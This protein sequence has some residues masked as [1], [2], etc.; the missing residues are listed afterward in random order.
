MSESSPADHRPPKS[1]ARLIGPIVLAI[2]FI[3]A[4]AAYPLAV[5]YLNPPGSF[6]HACLHNLKWNATGVIMYSN[7]YDDVGPMLEALGIGIRTLSGKLRAYGYAPRAKVLQ[8][9]S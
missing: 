7:D 6:N 1:S 5:G 2:I 3:A 9:A 4:A 8:K